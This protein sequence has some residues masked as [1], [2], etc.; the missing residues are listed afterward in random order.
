MNNQKPQLYFLLAAIIVTFILAFF[1]FHPF[2]YALILA[3]VFAVIFQ[4]IY[5]KIVNLFHGQQGLSAFTTILIVIIFIFIPIIF[6]GIQ[7]FQEA[8]QLYF[9]I[10]NNG[11]RYDFLNI[12]NNI[13]N[14]LKKYFPALQNFSI[15]TDQ[16]LKEWLNWPIQHIGAIFSGLAK[17]ITSS[18]IFFISFYYLLKDGKKLKKVI[19]ALSPLSNIDDEMILKK[20]GTAITSVI[21]GSLLIAIIQGI[22]T[23][24]GFMI[25]KVPNPVLWG[26]VAAIASIIP[27]VGTALVLTPAILFLFL[28]G[29]VF[30]GLC[31][32]AWGMGA[33]GLIDNFLGPKLMGQGIKLHPLIILFSVFGGISFFGFA[34]FILGPLTVTLLFALLDIY[35]SLM[36]KRN[37]KN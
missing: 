11:G 14:D 18:F 5:Q 23:T 17:I 2:I 19:I 34:G 28:K 3:I 30:Y 22:L 25:F 36:I 10:T 35:S 32:T 9:S 21:K 16:Y 4:P 24:I 6:L 31:L 13:I 1:I 15:N 7:I 29:E 37:L 27:G 26:T 12:L 8:E 33:V 20:L